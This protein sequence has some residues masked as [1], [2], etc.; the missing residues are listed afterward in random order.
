LA[1]ELEE[2]LG[3]KSELI[4]SSGGVFEVESAGQLIF[5][6]KALNRFPEDHEIVAITKCLESGMSLAQAQEEAAAGVPKPPDF[7]KWFA[8]LLAGRKRG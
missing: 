2:H 7:G 5:S 1:A 8:T 3:S 4:Q 6:K